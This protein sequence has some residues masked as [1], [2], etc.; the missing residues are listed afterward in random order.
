MAI[1]FALTPPTCFLGVVLAA[2]FF[3]F[4]PPAPLLGGSLDHRVEGL[5]DIHR[6]VRARSRV[7]VWRWIARSSATRGEK[8]FPPKIPK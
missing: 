1:T 2:E 8:N 5:V 3:F 4:L 6:E 7:V